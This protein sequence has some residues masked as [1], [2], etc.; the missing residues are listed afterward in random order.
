MLRA[1]SD[2]TPTGLQPRHE[3]QPLSWDDLTDHQ[4][5]AADGLC[6]LLAHQSEHGK[7]SSRFAAR[8]ETKDHSLVRVLPP[9]EFERHARVFLI[10][11]DRGSG[12]TA[13]LISLIHHWSELAQGRAPWFADVPAVAG[14]LPI[15]LFDLRLLPKRTAL[16]VHLASML[17]RLYEHVSDRSR[18]RVPLPTSPAAK[19]DPLGQAWN[20]FVQATAADEID[21][22]GRNN[23]DPE[24]LADEIYTAEKDRFDLSASFGELID[25][26]ASRYQK[27][28]KQVKPLFVIAIDDVDMSPDLVLECLELTQLFTHPRVAYVLTGH[29]NLCRLALEKSFR[30]QL[31]E[32]NQ[33]SPHSKELARKFYVKCIP[34]THQLRLRELTPPERTHHMRDVLRQVDLPRVGVDAATLFE[35]FPMLANALPG[36]MRELIDLRDPLLALR[37]KSP[38]ITQY[39]LLAWSLRAQ[40]E[41]VPDE[42]YGVM[43]RVFVERWE[44]QGVNV[45]RTNVRH[46]E[47]VLDVSGFTWKHV[48]LARAVEG[49]PEY[50]FLLTMNELV[51]V[52]P[53]VGTAKTQPSEEVRSW[54]LLA[55]I[56]FRDPDDSA[57]RWTAPSLVNLRLSY[58]GVHIETPW[59]FVATSLLAALIVGRAWRRW[60]GDG[61]TEPDLLARAYCECHILGVHKVIKLMPVTPRPWEELAPAMTAGPLEEFLLLAAPESGLEAPTRRKILESWKHSTPETRWTQLV[62]KIRQDRAERISAEHRDLLLHIFGDEDPWFVAMEYAG[63]DLGLL[64][65]L[66]SAPLVCKNSWTTTLDVY[67]TE[68]LRW[69][70]R[71]DPDA[72]DALVA[73]LSRDPK[74]DE[75]ARLASLVPG[76]MQWDGTRLRSSGGVDFFAGDWSPT[77]YVEDGSRRYAF[78]TAEGTIAWAGRD[79]PVASQIAFLLAH[80]LAMDRQPELFGQRANNGR[81]PLFRIEALE[82]GEVSQPWPSVGW[83]A[84]LDIRAS[85]AGWDQIRAN[86]PLTRESLG[87]VVREFCRL[88]LSVFLRRPYEFGLADSWA[89]L[90]EDIED[91]IAEKGDA[92]HPRVLAF[93]SWAGSLW[94]LVF[95]AAL[96]PAADTV[97]LLAELRRSFLPARDIST[98]IGVLAEILPDHGSDVLPGMVDRGTLDALLDALEL[99]HRSKNPSLF[100]PPVKRKR[101]AAELIEDLEQSPLRTSRGQSIAELLTVDLRDA[102]L[103]ASTSSIVA[104]STAL[105]SGRPRGPTRALVEAWRASGSREPNVVQWAGGRLIVNSSHPILEAFSEPSESASAIPGL[106]VR[107]YRGAIPRQEDH[108]LPEV[109]RALLA[110]FAY[111]P[112]EG[113]Y[114]PTHWA[115][116]RYTYTNTRTGKEYRAITPWPGVQWP[117]RRDAVMQ[118]AGWHTYLDQRGSH[119][120]AALI[121][122][123]ITLTVDVYE[124]GQPSNAGPGS[125]NDVLKRAWR[126]RNLASTDARD[127]AY[128]AWTEQLARFALPRVGL[129]NQYAA[130][131]LVRLWDLDQQDPRSQLLG[132]SDNFGQVELDLATPPDHPVLRLIEKKNPHDLA[133]F[134]NELRETYELGIKSD[135]PNPRKKKVVPRK[136]TPPTSKKKP[137]T[138]A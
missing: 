119:S 122:A 45:G 117:Q 138:K 6:R 18:E 98:M 80:D 76:L 55:A 88:E 65:E 39:T 57:Q 78:N 115:L 104:A 107:Y 94:T 111:V 28:S 51:T 2:E 54:L 82:S 106:R 66:S 22:R 84:H 46:L 114:A 41:Q 132:R 10:E 125:W 1:M 38:E 35:E 135:K 79:R 14:V 58:R 81:W 63:E 48:L 13:L 42:E 7:M 24:T 37:P 19:P 43:D 40:R 69:A 116:A 49:G 62:R 9:I 110:D 130:D 112:T 95:A 134:M 44:V 100:N 75:R 108:P 59:P 16:K 101:A 52:E 61:H 74:A 91:A 120:I 90:I 60:L 36:T 128:R 77:Q 25:Q 4:R 56:V 121:R 30:A 96:L 70:L 71:R 68:D 50:S 31:G 33:S 99:E 3:A 124:T 127:G 85:L 102:I 126:A 89:E 12:K 72:I 83:K 47:F 5:A 8:Y 23:V 86:S 11:G 93:A 137:S 67:L 64:G 17:R 29:D 97:A 129:S 113:A 27:G 15:G 123:Y 109:F 118:I 21:F 131:V 34:A 26:L 32:D 73:A 53:I 105:R 87:V 103:D 133:E 92:Q 136:K 20:E